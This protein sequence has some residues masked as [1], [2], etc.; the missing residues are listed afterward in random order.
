MIVDSGFEHNGTKVVRVLQGMI[1]VCARWQVLDSRL[2]T[3]AIWLS[4]ITLVFEMSFSFT[5]SE[6]RRVIMGANEP[7]LHSPQTSCR[8]I[9]QTGRGSFQPSQG[10][11]V[12][13]A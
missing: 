11:G 6:R 13:P 2:Q 12:T 10:T 7:S 5:L 9:E 3:S 8:K 1:P 4:F